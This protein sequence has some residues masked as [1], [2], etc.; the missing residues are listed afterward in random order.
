MDISS[1]SEHNND[2]KVVKK[3]G[4]KQVETVLTKAYKMEAPL[5]LPSR[6]TQSANF[7]D[8]LSI[9]LDPQALQQRDENRTAA[10][11]QLLMLQ[12]YQTQVATLTSQMMQKL[13]CGCIGCLIVR[14]TAHHPVITIIDP[15]IPIPI[16][17]SVVI[18]D[19]ITSSPLLLSMDFMVIVSILQ[20][21]LPTHHI[22]CIL[23]HVP[24][25]HDMHILL[26][27][28]SG[29]TGTRSDHSHL[30]VVLLEWLQIL[31]K[32]N[33][34]ASMP[35]ANRPTIASSSA[36]NLNNLASIAAGLPNAVA[37]GNTLSIR[38]DNEGYF[39]VQNDIFHLPKPSM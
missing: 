15:L 1:E 20:S 6:K 23:P 29:D 34:E 32:M 14:D 12:N 9:T 5:R 21:V 19:V 27:P 3:K 10:S 24:A 39:N 38:A 35:V 17:L 13:N 11:F 8:K 31:S 22:P 16:L 4:K 25:I 18:M 26:H 37:P 7:L 2:S 30:T 36:V 33:P 28:V